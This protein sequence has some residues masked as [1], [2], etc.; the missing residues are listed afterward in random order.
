[1]FSSLSLES[2]NASAVP[3]AIP[4][5]RTAIGEARNKRRRIQKNAPFSPENTKITVAFPPNLVSFG[6]QNG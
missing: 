6:N 2:V 4:A 5:W 1:L 3:E